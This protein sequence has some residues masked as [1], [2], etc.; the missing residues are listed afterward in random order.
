MLWSEAKGLYQPAARF[1]IQIN[2][3]VPLAGAKQIKSKRV[4]KL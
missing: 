1:L 4:V 3:I 2:K